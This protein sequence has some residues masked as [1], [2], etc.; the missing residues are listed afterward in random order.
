VPAGRRATLNGEEVWL[1]SFAPEDL[2]L[3]SVRLADGGTMTV[4][5]S[6]LWIAPARN[7]VVRFWANIDL[8][9][10]VLLDRQLPVTGR[11]ILRYDLFDVGT[12][13]NITVPFGC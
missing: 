13:V 9:N 2:V 10:A 11:L 3:P 8:E 12:A 4:E 1:Y 7:A 6:E 5:S